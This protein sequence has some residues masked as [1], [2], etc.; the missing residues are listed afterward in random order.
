[1][2]KK[3]TPA[4]Q[5]PKKKKKS[6]ADKKNEK[7]ISAQKT[8]RYKEMAK[9]GIC[10]V[11]GKTYSKTIRF[12]DINYQ[13][14]QNE[15]KNAI[16]ENWCDFLNYFDSSIHFQLS[17]IN[18]KSNMK[19]FERVIRI[20]P[21]NDAFDDVR[22]EYA[23]MLKNQLA[24]GN[25]GLVKTKSAVADGLVVQLPVE[26]CQLELSR[27]KIEQMKA[28]G[29][30]MQAECIEEAKAIHKIIENI[31]R[32]NFFDEVGILDIMP[33]NNQILQKREGYS[34]IFAAYTMLDLA[35]QLE[36]KGK[37]EVYEGESKN[38]ALLYEYWLFFEL[39]KIVKSIEGCTAVKTQE[40]PFLL[41][42][43][44]ITISLE[45]G[46]KSCQSFQIK[47]HGV[48]INLYYN[49]TFSRKEFK[50]TKYEGSYSRPF[51]PDYTLAIFP[52]SFGKGKYNGEEEAI[53]NGAVSYIHFDAKYRISDLTSLIGN[54]KESELD[55]AELVDDKIESVVNTYKRG[56]LLM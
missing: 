46:K 31:F 9:D 36:W 34:Q 5:D 27:R 20:R 1:M 24:K 37:D 47:R 21:R 11:Q 35:L 7:K 29:Q 51:R 33:Q 39:Y 6:S 16:F 15:D 19:E 22:M 56:D 23:Q 30:T 4:I 17:F 3:K 28:D 2:S 26:S 45:E 42:E 13:L 38:V 8:I 49:R 14:A 41:L 32:D 50:T 43:N 18:H 40:D 48:K 53:A 55:E 25:N 52:I 54:N 44:G 12:Y 10:R